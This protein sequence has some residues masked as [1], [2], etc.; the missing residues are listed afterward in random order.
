M[1]ASPPQEAPLPALR[2][3]LQLVRGAPDGRGGA[4]WLVF[5]AIRH[6]YF[7][8]DQNTRDVL[9]HWA[10]IDKS[11]FIEAVRSKTGREV[12]DSEIDRIVR[13]LIANSLTADAPQD[14]ARAYAKQLAAARQ[15]G[16][17]KLLHSYL[18]VRVPLFRP[19][20][21]LVATLPFV[22][23]LF[24]RAALA[25]VVTATLSGVYLVS[26]QWQTFTAT[27]LDFLSLEGALLYGFSLIAVKS[28]HELGHAYTAT[29]YG[30]RVNTMGVAFMLMVPVLYT[31][32]TDSWKLRSRKQLLT[33]AGAGMAVEVAIAGLA[34][35]L[36]VFL[37]DGPLRSVA[38]VLAT[39]SWV[40]SL[41]INLNPFMRFD[42]YYLLSDALA[43]ANLQSRSFVMARWWMR[44]VLFGLGAHPPEAVS[45]G[46]RRFLIG[47]AIGTWIYR[48]FLFIGIALLVYHM[49]FK[50]LGIA[51][52][53][54][55]IVW[56]VLRPIFNELTEW[57]K[58]REKIAR[59]VTTYITVALALG[60]MAFLVVP[61]S[62]T[63]RVPA[64]ALAEHEFDIFA[65]RSA[66]VAEINFTPDRSVSKNAQLVV[67]KSSRLEHEMRRAGYA[68]ELAEARLRRIAGD[69]QERAART[70]IAQE[71]ESAR[72]RLTVL[73][74]QKTQLT[75]TA[76]F[77]GQVR[78]PM[79]SLA[80][81]DWIDTKTRIGRLV[82]NI[83]SRVQGY[84]HEDDVWKIK[85][86]QSVL[87][88]PED[89]TLPHR[90]G[91]LLEIAQAG[92]QELEIAYLS[93]VYGGA[94][95][96]DQGD[97]ETV[98]PRA[99]QY[100]IKVAIENANFDRVVRGTLHLQGRPESVAFAAWRRVLQVLVR[101][102]G[103]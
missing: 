82:S 11:S 23:I 46:T 53:I 37:P 38:F 100:L 16:W 17:Q 83:G 24:T 92:S 31:D 78:D 74:E 79:P 90:K 49:F 15:S 65:P 6:R 97:A 28:L 39:T 44:E 40:L 57:W 34:T 60:A 98:K 36:W 21:F 66:Q 73:T 25:L 5:D 87:F 52:F 10:R 64:V 29:R 12:D 55:E 9:A 84:I 61:R 42:G 1:I 8:I 22:A 43:I 93:S 86:G 35:F 45:V 58:M 27:F 95:P 3:D 59:S 2:D 14:D 50:I 89:P 67:L 99:G 103:F 75:L 62:T 26:R 18:F 85:S 68:I 69:D 54:I 13:F 71:L 102:S 20:A 94:I 51:L 4:N 56:F 47:Y 80:V 33:I 19:H 77:S 7:Q 63:V 91:R 48:L 30:V 76:P 41:L 70:I 81:G 96:S 32:V 88:V 72:K 101:E